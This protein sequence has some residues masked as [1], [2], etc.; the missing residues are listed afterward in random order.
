MFSSAFMIHKCNVYHHYLYE[1]FIPKYYDNEDDIIEHVI[2]SYYN[3][4]IL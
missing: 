1:N 4:F 3:S 2:I